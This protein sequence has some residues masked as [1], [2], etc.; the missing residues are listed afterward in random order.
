[1]RWGVTNVVALWPKIAELHLEQTAGT[2]ALQTLDQLA[3]GSCPPGQ[4]TTQIQQA[5]TTLQ[6]A[7]TE[8]AQNALG[9]QPADGAPTVTYGVPGSHQL[10]FQL[11]TLSFFVWIL[12]AILT[13]GVGACV[14]VVFN[15]GFGTTQDLIQCFIWG[16]GMP[17]V[18]QGFG[19]LSAAPSHQHSHCRSHGNV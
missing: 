17:A 8:N 14:L 5:L 10:T 12:W 1:M 9:G 15:D 16:A 13:V 18:G 7:I 2:A 19:G 3:T 6:V 4:L 11:E